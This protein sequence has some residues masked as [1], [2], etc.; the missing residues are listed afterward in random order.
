MRTISMYMHSPIINRHSEKQYHVIKSPIEG[1]A[2]GPLLLTLKVILIL[3]ST[4]YLEFHTLNI[5]N[6]KFPTTT[7]QVKQ[8]MNR[9]LNM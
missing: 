5:Q 4:D 6:M 1:A 9:Q 2:P 7:D 8:R 3:L